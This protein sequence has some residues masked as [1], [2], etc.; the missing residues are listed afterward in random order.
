MRNSRELYT[1]CTNVN[2]G[3]HHVVWNSKTKLT[4]WKGLLLNESKLDVQIAGA[5][6]NYHTSVPLLICI[7]INYV[8]GHKFKLPIAAAWQI[9]KAELVMSA[10]NI[11][12]YLEVHQL[13]MALKVYAVPNVFDHNCIKY[14]SG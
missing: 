11:L 14:T 13:D 2:M 4:R 7:K 6:Y 10:H 12:C 9:W 8:A 1:I 3:Y 5:F